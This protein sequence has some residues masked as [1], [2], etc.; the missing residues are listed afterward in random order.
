MQAKASESLEATRREELSGAP[1]VKPIA[2]FSQEQASVTVAG[3]TV[4]EERRR[5]LFGHGKP[6]NLQG[7]IGDD[8]AHQPSNYPTDRYTRNDPANYPAPNYPIG[9]ELNQTDLSK[10]AD[11]NKMFGPRIDL[12]Q[13]AIRAKIFGYA[14]NEKG[15][16][17]PLENL[18]KPPHPP[19]WSC[20]SCG[21]VWDLSPGETVD[22][23]PT[24]EPP[25]F[26]KEQAAI[27]EDL[28]ENRRFEVFGH[29]KPLD[30][31]GHRTE[32]E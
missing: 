29:K 13:E 24:A 23:K 26:T 10:E 20:P 22:F 14:R 19:Q 30:S 7:S 2:G 15:E 16:K 3:D 21:Q 28:E 9:P 32:T 31:R 27:L 5:E 12:G 25:A 1:T 17:V 6:L 11:R 4:E 18:T 8:P